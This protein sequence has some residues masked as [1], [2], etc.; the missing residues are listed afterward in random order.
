MQLADGIYDEGLFQFVTYEWLV[1][2]GVPYETIKKGIARA[3]QSWSKIHWSKDKRIKLIRYDTIPDRTVKNYGLPAADQL[4]A[5]YLAATSKDSAADTRNYI[6][7]MVNEALEHGYLGWMQEYDGHPMERQRDLARSAAVAE[8][9]LRFIDKDWKREKAKE[10]G[11]KPTLSDFHG[12]V[13]N[14]GLKHFKCSNRSFLNAKLIE[15]RNK[16]IPSVIKARSVPKTMGKFRSDE[17]FMGWFWDLRSS[18]KN[19]NAATIWRKLK[20]LCM[21]SGRP[22]PEYNTVNNLCNLTKVKLLTAETRFD[23][24]NRAKQGYRNYVPLA[25]PEHPGDVWLFDGTRANMVAH[26]ADGGKQKFLYVT[27]C[28]DGR[29][30]YFV[31][32]WYSHTESAECYIQ[33]IK[34]AVETC[35]Y[36]PYEMR[37]DKFPGHDSAEWLAVSA[38]LEA[39]GV[40]LTVS[41]SPTG[42]AWVER[43]FRTVQSVF[44]QELDV[45]YGEGV[46][47]SMATAHRKA[48]YVARMQRS[49]RKYGFGFKEAVGEWE[50]LMRSYN[51]APFNAYLA[52]SKSE[53]SPATLHS[54][55]KPNAIAATA[56]RVAWL[57]YE[58]RGYSIT[59][60]LIK[61]THDGNEWFYPVPLEL[62]K[63]YE[64]AVV[65][66][67]LGNMEK[68]FC[69]REDG[70]LLAELERSDPTR[71]NGP[72]A[73]F[74][75]LG[76]HRQRL[77]QE[78]KQMKEELE[79]EKRPM[80]ELVDEE[81][82]EVTEVQVNV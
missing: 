8:V 60:G 58:K 31:S 72:D 44:A 21:A 20:D 53:D 82:G 40:K 2:Y 22:A 66:F 34:M 10:L 29:S 1:S 24:S 27:A 36:L 57:C 17:Q 78:R 41:S 48:Q 16:G 30:G 65:A 9:G 14:L 79:Q 49:A 62:R 6:E 52:K 56:D 33:C 28:Y 55:E 26:T 45:Y 74:K 13:K 81:T 61:V 25:K 19:Y 80:A 47:S 59:R 68:V 67:D 69:F 43:A 77:K 37:F 38:E 51:H 7:Q 4:K 64:H 50:K 73:D 39:L 46:R 76:K 35:G 18:E 54:A 63:L 5:Q 71:V 42:K 12:C 11:R 75:A 70:V 15:C 32:R 23:D 3:G